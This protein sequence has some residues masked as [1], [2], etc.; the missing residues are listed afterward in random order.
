VGTAGIANCHL[1]DGIEM[2]VPL[3]NRGEE[4]MTSLKETVQ[5][6][7]EQMEDVQPRLLEL[8]HYQQ[9]RLA[10]KK[11]TESALEIVQQLEGEGHFPQSA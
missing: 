3:P 9:P 2:V 10:S 1:I 11:R 8:L 6:S 7:Y 4:A 5:T